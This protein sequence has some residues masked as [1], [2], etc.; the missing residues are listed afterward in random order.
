MR[1]MVDE[2]TTATRPRCVECARAWSDEKERW[3][4]F[5]TVDDETALYCP[6]C[7]H[8]EFDAA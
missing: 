3:R 8:A 7:A 1:A 2:S 6:G 4:L 5:L